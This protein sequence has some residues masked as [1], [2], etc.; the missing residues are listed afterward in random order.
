[1]EGQIVTVPVETAEGQVQEA[2][3]EAVEEQKKAP[4]KKTCL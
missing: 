1:V 3:T 2:G 4:K